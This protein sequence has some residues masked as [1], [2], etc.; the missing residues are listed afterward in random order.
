MKQKEVQC[1]RCHKDVKDSD[2]WGIGNKAYVSLHL[3]VKCKAEFDK[4]MRRS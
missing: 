2:A 3:C 4:W 1:D